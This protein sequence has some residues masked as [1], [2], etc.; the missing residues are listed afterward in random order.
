MPAQAVGKPPKLP[1]I[2]SDGRIWRDETQVWWERVWDSPMAG[3]ILKGDLD[4]LIVLA[5]L[6]DN[7]WREPTAGLAAEIRQQRQAFGLTPLDRRRL[8][9]E[10]ER[11]EGPKRG[12]KVP[13]QGKRTRRADPRDA[14]SIV[15]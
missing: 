1:E 9:W 10:I 13:E 8:E 6:M 14:L 11:V 2:R 3:E 15:Q 7:F 12:G 5:Y 4:Q